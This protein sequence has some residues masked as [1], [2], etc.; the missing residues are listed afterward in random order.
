MDDTVY[1]RLSKARKLIQQAHDEI[2]A[3]PS[4]AAREHHPDTSGT[5]LSMVLPG[6]ELLTKTISGLLRDGPHP[7]DHDLGPPEK[8]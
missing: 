4:G 7:Y 6:L 3:I 5:L 1:Q 8:R 2:A